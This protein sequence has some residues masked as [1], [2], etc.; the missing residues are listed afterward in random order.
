MPKFLWGR[1]ILYFADFCITKR[2]GGEY[3]YIRNLFWKDIR[4]NCRFMAKI[5]GGGV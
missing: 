3:M 2:K 4:I 1:K 5:Y